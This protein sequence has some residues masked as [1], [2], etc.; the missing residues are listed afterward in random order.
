M[1]IC[2]YHTIINCKI[3]ASIAYQFNSRD[4]SRSGGDA[5]RVRRVLQMNGF[6]AR[7]LRA[8]NEA[9]TRR[10]VLARKVDGAGNEEPPY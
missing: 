5:S 4:A 2:L 8:K 10:R 9:A 6:P 7:Q 3:N 1:R